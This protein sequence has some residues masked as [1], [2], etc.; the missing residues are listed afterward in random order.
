[1][2]SV[3]F[4]LQKD[5]VCNRMYLQNTRPFFTE[6]KTPFLQNTRSFFTEHEP[7]FYRTRGPFLQNTKALFTEHGNPFYRT[8]TTPKGSKE[9]VIGQLPNIIYIHIY[10]SQSSIL[11]IHINIWINK[12][13]CSSII[14]SHR[15]TQHSP[16]MR[17]GRV[18][19]A[20]RFCVPWTTRWLG[21]ESHLVLCVFFFRNDMGVPQNVVYPQWWP[22]YRENHGNIIVNYMKLV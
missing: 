4:V 21:W 1:M 14:H 2:C 18:C 9:N 3:T 10:I 5:C 13:T 20:H 17:L 16:T 15:G 12:N 7:L 11:A 19:V 22:C 6:H 8:R